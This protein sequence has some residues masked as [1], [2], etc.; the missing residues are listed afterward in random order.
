MSMYVSF[1][2]LKRT[3]GNGCDNPSVMASGSTTTVT[4]HRGG[5]RAW[6]IKPTV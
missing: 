5:W 1:W 2:K 6:N 4:F 3:W